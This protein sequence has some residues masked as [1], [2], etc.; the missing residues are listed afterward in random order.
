MQGRVEQTVGKVFPCQFDA[1][2][3]IGRCCRA[4]TK[5]VRKDESDGQSVTHAWI[6]QMMAAGVEKV[7]DAVGR[8]ARR[9]LAVAHEALLRSCDCADV[10]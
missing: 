6:E 7:G 2:P 8:E 3:H 4:K 9:R 1:S 5:A 10:V